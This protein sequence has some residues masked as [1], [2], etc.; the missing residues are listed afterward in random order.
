MAEVYSW[1]TPVWSEWKKSLDA[2]RFPNSVI[3][4][5]PE[6]L[7]VEALVSQLT[8][9][10]MC[11]NYESEACGF[12][13]SCELMKSGSHP[14]FHVIEPEKEGKSITVDQV[15]ASNRWAQ[16]SSQLGGLRVIL[17]NPAEAMNES[18]SNALLKTLEEPASNCIFILSTRNSN[19]LMPTILSR[20]QQFNVVCPQL[21]AGSE[22]LNGEVGKTVPQYIL[23]LND[24]APL[25][26]KAM[27][28]QGGVEASTK[29][30]DGFVDV[31]KGVQPDMLKFSTELSKEPLVQLGWLWHLL[32]DVQKL[33]FGLV[34]EAITP[35]ASV[36]SGVMSYQSAYA[37]SNKLLILIEQ[38]KQHPGLNTELLI[39]NWLIATCEE[40]CS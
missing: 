35:S 3:V 24:N 5:A 27:F 18:A 29:A 37:A 19:R 10:L 20:C 21:D 12:C 22:W 31:I 36:L 30:L 38:L 9:A 8:S 25:K 13:H 32:S 28:D 4:N 6:G 15:R 40:T 11:V 34:S 26:A 23:A 14:D 33:H 1:L 17:L 39:M 16:Q 7:G 2:E